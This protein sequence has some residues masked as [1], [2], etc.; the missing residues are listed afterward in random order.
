MSS[1][2]Q[3]N[4]KVRAPLTVIHSPDMPAPSKISEKPF[5]W[6]EVKQL[7][8]EN[9]LE[10]FA[11]S[12]QVTEKYIAFKKQLKQNESTVFK[13]L[14]TNS[15]KWAS[16]KD[17]QGLK[18]SEIIIPSLG[19]PLFQDASDLKLV[20]NDFPYYFEPD[21]VHLCLWSKNR[22]QSDKNSAIGDLSPETRAL[23]E[24]YVT[25]LFVD[26]LGVPRDNLVWFRNWEALQSV[27]EISHVHIL[28][29]G[30]T[31][32]QLAKALDQ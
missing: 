9:D 28:I 14:V 4:T 31:A 16:Q 1:T 23:I 2:L 13:H 18:D 5:A 26:G 24:S 32:E 21:V 15:L 10:A 8:H 6:S 11:R 25:K 22:I 7:V 29:K 20:Q 19:H 3:I 17:V 30:M 12:K 27:R